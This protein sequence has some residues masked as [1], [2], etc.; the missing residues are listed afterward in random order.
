MGSST[1]WLTKKER[2]KREI[3]KKN[4]QNSIGDSERAKAKTLVY[5]STIPGTPNHRSIWHDYPSAR[6]SVAH[7]PQTRL[8]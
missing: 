1:Y 3:Q 5:F 6:A 4:N 2:R 8:T 7:D